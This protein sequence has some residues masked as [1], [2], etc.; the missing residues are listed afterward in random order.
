M[1]RLPHGESFVYAGDAAT[2]ADFYRTAL[3]SRGYR[4]VHASGDGL[5]QAWRGDDATVHL[6][7]AETPGS[8]PLTRIVVEVGAE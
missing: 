8:N 3:P 1:V 5:L 7:L 2:A 6:A 4:L